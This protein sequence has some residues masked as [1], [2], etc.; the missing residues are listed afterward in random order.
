MKLTKKRLI[1]LIAQIKQAWKF[2]NC[3]KETG[4]SCFHIK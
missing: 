1:H 2:A 3:Q 4:I